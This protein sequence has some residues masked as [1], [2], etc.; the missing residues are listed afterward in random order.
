MSHQRATSRRCKLRPRLA[1]RAPERTGIAAGQTQM[2][3][4]SFLME[5]FADDVRSGV[6]VDAYRHRKR[7]F[8]TSP[9]LA[10]GDAVWSALRRASHRTDQFQR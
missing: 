10:G 4:A 1:A 9:P 3:D 6:A 5:S 2:P 7:V 8:E